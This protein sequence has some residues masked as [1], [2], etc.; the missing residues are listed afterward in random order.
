MGV[1]KAQEEVCNTESP[2]LVDRSE[3]NYKQWA[4][5]RTIDHFREQPAKIEERCE[6]NPDYAHN[7]ATNKSDH[8]I[9]TIETGSTI[10]LTTSVLIWGVVLNQSTKMLVDTGA[11]VTVISDAYYHDIL[12]SVYHLKQNTWLYSVITANGNSIP[13]TG[14]VS[15]PVLIGQSKYSCDASIVPGLAYNIVLGRDFLHKFSAFIDV[16][17]HTVK[18]APDNSVSFVNKDLPPHASEVRVAQKV[19]VDASSESGNPAYLTTPPSENIIGLI[20]AVPKLSDR[21][22]LFVAS[23]VSSP[24]EDGRVSFCLLNPTE[25]PVLLHKGTTIGQFVENKSD[26][27]II[28]LESEPFVSCKPTRPIEPKEQFLSRFASFPSTPLSEDEI[29]CLAELLEV[30]ADIFASSSLDLGRTNIVQ[31]SIDTGE[32]RPIKQPP[33]CVS[34][35]QR[36]EI[37]RH[38]AN[39]LKQGILDVSS[40]PWSSPVVLVKKKDGT[41]RFCVDYRKLNAVTRKDS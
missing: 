34:Q 31:H 13:V 16:R 33:Y 9:P 26:A 32:A 4:N 23:S 8:T 37:E 29:K 7:S 20:E 10:P 36:A 35:T 39:M 27:T 3:L 38:I 1:L 19:S 40:S 22:H 41:T 6:H 24:G 30:Y 21:Y 14:F 11:A 5:K 18:V 12:Q 15:F 2:K 17:G 28:S 25:Q